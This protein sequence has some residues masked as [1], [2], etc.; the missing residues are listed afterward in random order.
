MT[1]HDICGVCKVI[2]QYAVIGPSLQI[3]STQVEEECETF[4]Q[5]AEMVLYR[6]KVIEWRDENSGCPKPLY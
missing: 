3:L 4:G 2:C 5:V 6:M 1:N